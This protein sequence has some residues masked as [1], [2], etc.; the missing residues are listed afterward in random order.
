MDTAIPPLSEDAMER[1]DARQQQLTKPPGSL[2]RLEDLATRIAGMTGEATPELDAPVIVTMAGDHGVVEEGISAFPKEVTTQMVANMA[3]GGA[4]VNTLAT[5]SGAKNLIVDVGVEDDGYPD[6]GTVIKLP[7]GPG[8]KNFAEEPAMTRE[9]AEAAIETGRKVVREHA[10]D[11]DIIA[12][13]DMGIGNT[14]PSAAVTASITGADVESVTG[15]GTGIDDEGLGRKISVIEDALDRHDP[16]PEDGLD[17]LRTVGGFEIGGLAGVA[18]EAA[19]QRTPVVIDGFIT[20]AA[21][22]IAAAIDEQVTEYLLPSHCSVESGH[23]VQYDWLG[24][25]T[26]FDLEMRLGEGTGAALAIPM[27]QGACTSLRE[28]ATFEE[29]GVASE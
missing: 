21:A 25:E 3:M 2:G 6:D 12:L 5:V 14:T 26:L 29:A 28:M 10:A 16:D 7:V 23:A 1:A 4:A 24:L 8:T 13:G 18:L 19:S 15:R 17:V 22:L 27:Y 11:A 9:Q 20:G